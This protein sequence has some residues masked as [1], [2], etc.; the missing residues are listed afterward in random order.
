MGP[1]DSQV[2][3]LFTLSALKCLG[4][5]PPGAGRHAAAAAPALLALAGHLPGRPPGQRPHQHS[6]SLRPPPA[7]PMD[8]FLLNLALLHLGCISTAL[9][10]AVASALW[11]SRDISC[12][13]CA[14]QCFSFSYSSQQ[15]FPFSLPCP[16]SAVLP[17][18]SPCTIGPQTLHRTLVSSTA[19]ATV[20]AAPWAVG[21]SMLSCSPAPR[22]PVCTHGHG[23]PI[24]GA[25]S[26]SCSRYISCNW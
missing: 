17:S 25:E 8:F 16:M 18:A 13:A 21:S 5:P 7:H 26:D 11:D 24:P 20:A 22:P 14:A 2:S 19:C 12:A 4:V 1:F 6:R 23:C 3:Q 10:K 15:Q 9:P